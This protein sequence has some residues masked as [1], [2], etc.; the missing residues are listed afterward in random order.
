M[1]VPAAIFGPGIAIVTRTDVTPSPAVNIG[2]AQELSLDFA[3]STKQLFGQNQFPL[4]AA[5]STVKVSGK[6]KAATLS[7]I[8]M[9]NIF[10]GSSFTPASGFAWNINEAHSVP[11]SSSYTVTVTNSAQFD[12]DLGVTYAVSG[13]PLQRV[14]SVTAAGQYS[15]SA[16]VYTFDVADASA[17]LLFTYT[18]TITTATSQ[19]LIVTNQPI[20]FTPTFQLD[21]YTSLSQPTAE[22]YAVRVFN[23][24][25]AKLSMGF[26]LEDFMMPE[27][28]FDVFANPAGQVF[29][30]V[31]P[32]IA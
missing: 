8:A 9:N 29:E 22:P 28:D 16:G 10:F 25:A 13:L 7:G 3:G 6:M 12:A 23:C 15:V 32:Q 30:T 4:V 19:K 26:K 20:G 31:F 17:A 1:S 5:R 14:T 24:V 11:A 18:S 27:F 21:Y 2:Y